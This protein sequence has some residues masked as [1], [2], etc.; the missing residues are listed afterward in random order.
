MKLRHGAT[1]KICEISLAEVRCKIITF[2]DIEI[3]IWPR[4]HSAIF[5]SLLGLVLYIVIDI[6]LY[7]RQLCT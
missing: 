1:E 2:L 5:L 4:S 6:N 7:M 3:Q